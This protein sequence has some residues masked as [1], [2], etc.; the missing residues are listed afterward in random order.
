MIFD[1]LSKKV[2]TCNTGAFDSHKCSSPSDQET[3]KTFKYNLLKLSGYFLE[4][5]LKISTT[6][7]LT[8]V[9]LIPEQYWA[10]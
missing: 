2:S 3:I 1:A 6:K 9:W 10:F 8:M 5:F 7:G 4:N